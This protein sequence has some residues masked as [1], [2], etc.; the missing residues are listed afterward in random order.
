MKWRFFLV[1]VLVVGY[2]MLVAGAPLIAVLGGIAIAAV[3]NLKQQGTWRP[4][5]SK[6]SQDQM[7]PA[8]TRT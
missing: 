3:L 6:K 4:R 8:G 7:I 2:A 5:A 1:A